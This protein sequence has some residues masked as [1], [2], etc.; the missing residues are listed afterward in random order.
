MYFMAG[1]MP[2]FQKY[3]EMAEHDALAAIQDNSGD[4]QNYLMLYYLY[5]MERDYQRALDVL[6]KLQAM[7]PNERS[8]SDRIAQLQAMMNVKAAPDTAMLKPKAR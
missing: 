6:Q 8:I 7:F 2:Q 4:P 1:T 3:A 5:D